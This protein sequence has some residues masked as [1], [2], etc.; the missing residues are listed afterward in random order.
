MFSR[1]EYAK[2]FHGKPDKINPLINS[3][4][5]NINENVKIF[6]NIPFGKNKNLNIK[7]AIA[8]NRLIKA[9]IRIIAKGIKKI[10]FLSYKSERGIQYRFDIKYPNPKKYP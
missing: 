4:N 9:G 2:R 10:K 7:K 6:V 5:P 3:K 1:K 8:K